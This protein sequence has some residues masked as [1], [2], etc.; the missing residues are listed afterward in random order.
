M[1]FPRR[2]AALAACSLALLAG[3]GDDGSSPPRV[4]PAGDLNFVLQ[5]PDAP[6]LSAT[7]K[8]FWAKRG[9]DREVRLFYRPRPGATDSAEF[10]RF[11]V[12]EQTLLASPTGSSYAVG[13]SVLITITVPDPTRFVVN[14]E[15]ANLR[16]WS[17]EPAELKWKLCEA[18]EDLDGDDDVDATDAA[19]VSD[20][21]VWRQQTVGLPWAALA[22]R[23]EVELCEIEAD[24]TGFSN[25]AVAY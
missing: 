14:M 1:R 25:F 24:I 10:L 21:R 16:F 17:A 7:V 9:E 18:D 5:A 3:C 19:L 4:R 20:L 11:R 13:D 12:G 15:P 8:T 23:L 22:T 6:T 2:I